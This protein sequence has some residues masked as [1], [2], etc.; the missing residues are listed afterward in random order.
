MKILFFLLL[1]VLLFG[2]IG[3]TQNLFTGVTN[4]TIASIAVPDSV[5]VQFE[6]GPWLLLT[7]SVDDTAY[8]TITDKLNETTKIF[9]LANETYWTYVN[10]MRFKIQAT[11][12]DTITTRYIGTSGLNGSITLFLRPDTSGTNT[13]YSKS[14]LVG[15]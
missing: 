10:S 11:A 2:Q 15:R 3:F 8:V 14:T 5:Y 13:D 1:P 12:T 4:D 9:D 6:D 7:S